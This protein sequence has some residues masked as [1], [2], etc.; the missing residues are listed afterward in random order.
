MKFTKMHGCGNDYIYVNL[1]EE[2]IENASELSRKVSDRHIGI[3]GDGLITIGA[4]DQADFRMR[5]YNADG[6]EAEMCGNGIRCVAKYVYE[7]GMT[8]Q[9]EIAI[10]TASGVLKLQLITES[11]KVKQVRVDMGVPVIEASKIP[12]VCSREIVLDE[13]IFA[14]GRDWRMT[15]V[16]MGNPHA[17]VFVPSVDDLLLEKIGPEFEHHTRFPNRVN[18]EF[19]EVLSRT[20]MRMRVWERG[21]G[22]T[23]ACGTGTCACVMA[24]ILNEYTEDHVLVHLKGGDLLIDYDRISGHIYMTGP[25]ETVF[26]GTFLQEC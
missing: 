4:S 17:V 14:A 5:I 19:V 1:L 13:Q 25:A 10:E 26:E 18:T 22:E 16:S 15:C 21:S 6:S 7:H 11:G 20:E 24:A 3:G 12:V 2:T 23:L 8:D 9:T